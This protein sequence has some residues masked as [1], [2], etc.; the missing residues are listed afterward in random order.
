V[1]AQ[2]AEV[3]EPLTPI[4]GTFLIIAWAFGHSL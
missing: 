1:L 3:I 4:H 2:A